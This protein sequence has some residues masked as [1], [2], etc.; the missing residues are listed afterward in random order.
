MSFKG[1]ESDFGEGVQRVG[2]EGA[3]GTLLKLDGRFDHISS[4]L[5]EHF[6]LAP[7]EGKLECLHL[8][9]CTPESSKQKETGYRGNLPQG[10]I[11][12]VQLKS[13]W[14]H[15]RCPF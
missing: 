2:L 10:F 9:R 12:T 15:W 8:N 11:P 6:G 7:S 1:S 4:G 3:Q 13:L 14:F 5:I